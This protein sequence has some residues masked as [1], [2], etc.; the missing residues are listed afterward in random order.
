MLC[1]SPMCGEAEGTMDWA[2]RGPVITCWQCDPPVLHSYW[3]R[4]KLPS[5]TCG[6]T[7]YEFTK[8]NPPELSQSTEA[9]LQNCEIIN[10]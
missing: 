6:G 9:C 5:E 10:C 2:G 3:Q 4:N 8:P 1:G 7:W